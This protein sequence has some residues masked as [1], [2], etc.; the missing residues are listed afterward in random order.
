[1]VDEEK[2]LLIARYLVENS[3]EKYLELN[4]SNMITVGIA[5]SRF[6]KLV[7]NLQYYS[8]SQEKDLKQQIS[9]VFI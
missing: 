8:E 4:Y 1:M 7:G 5:K 9:N 6:K 2:V 3:N